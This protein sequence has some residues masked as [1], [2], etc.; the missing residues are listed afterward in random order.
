MNSKTGIF[1]G[2]PLA[3]LTA[4][5][6]NTLEISGKLNRT[7][8]RYL[9]ILRHHGLELSTQERACVAAACDFGFISPDEI[10]TLPSE[11][12]LCEFEMEG[13]DKETLAAK[14]SSAS[15]A[16]LVSLVETLG[17]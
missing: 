1:F 16:D 9:A 2:P 14:L 12:A 11:V 5:A 7:A 13:V 17:F 10:R 15:F 8:E 3:K 6:A 4:S